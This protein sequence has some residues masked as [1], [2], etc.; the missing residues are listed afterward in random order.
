MT[1]CETP[2]RIRGLRKQFGSFT[3][4]DEVNLDVDAGSVHG[5]LGP[6]GAGKSTTMRILLGMYRR[7]AGEVTVLGLD[8]QRHPAQVTRQVSYVPGDVILQPNL[9]GQQTLDLLARLRGKRDTARE[10]ELIERFA[11]DPTKKVRS[12][13]TGNRQKVILVAA[14]SAPTPLLILDEPTSGLDP[15]MERV[16]GECVTETAAA[17]R[18]VLLSSHLLPEVD[19]LCSAV[20]IIADGRIVESGSLRHLR[21]LAA[22]QLTVRDTPERLSTIATALRRVM[23]AAPHVDADYLYVDVQHT[24]LPGALRVLADANPDTVHLAPASLESLFLRYYD[25][26]AR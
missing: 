23:A 8:P 21:E 14:F 16:F 24:E 10:A 4:L 3:A 26:E 15:L 18:T 6:N 11:L 12:Y 17:G 19:R 5:F 22:M 2:V 9:T 20:S 13:S 1:I 7:D 25:I